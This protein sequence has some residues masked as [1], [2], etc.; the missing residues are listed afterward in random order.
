MDKQSRAYKILGA[1]QKATAERDGLR[2]SENK[3]ELVRNWL[4]KYVNVHASTS[5]N[6][7]KIIRNDTIDDQSSEEW[8]EFETDDSAKDPD[9]KETIDS[10]NNSTSSD[11]APGLL[12]S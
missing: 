1:A 9:F 12:R 11:C 3:Q 10:S 7:S 6:S 8:S 4:T 5:Y 2:E